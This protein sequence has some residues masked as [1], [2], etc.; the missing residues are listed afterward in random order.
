MWNLGVGKLLL[1]MGKEIC[2]N[3]CNLN[4]CSSNKYMC[5]QVKDDKDHVVHRSSDISVFVCL[6]YCCSLSFNLFT[7]KICSLYYPSVLLCICTGAWTLGEVGVL[8]AFISYNWKMMIETQW[9][10]IYF[11]RAYFGNKEIWF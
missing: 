11:M 8:C 7:L 5:K 2:C 10:K 9:T 1:L 4:I 6:P 3:K